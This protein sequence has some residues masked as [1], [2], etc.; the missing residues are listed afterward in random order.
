MARIGA[1]RLPSYLATCSSAAGDSKPFP[2]FLHRLSPLF[3]RDWHHSLSLSLSLW[4]EYLVWQNA[5]N[6]GCC[7]TTTSLVISVFASPSPPPPAIHTHPYVV[8]FK[9]EAKTIGPCKGKQ[10]YIPNPAFEV[11]RSHNKMVSSKSCEKR[12]DL[13]S[14][15]TIQTPIFIYLV[16]FQ[17]AYIEEQWYLAGAL[18]L[19]PVFSFNSF[20]SFFVLVAFVSCSFSRAA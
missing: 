6:Q 7:F 5:V 16:R 9:R 17:P 3:S 19:A 15:A 11:I 18:I 14:F 1:C 13:S 2:W 4:Y 12:P 8:V 20:I 10:T